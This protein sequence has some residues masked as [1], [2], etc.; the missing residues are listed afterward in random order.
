MA[1]MATD[2]TASALTSATIG[3]GRTIYV[4]STAGTSLSIQGTTGVTTFDGII[5]DKTS[6]GILVKQ[7]TGTLILGGASTYTGSTSINNGT[8]KLQTGNDRLPIGTTLNIGQATSTNLGTFD[9]NGFNQQIAGLV[10]TSGTNT[11]TSKNTVTS[12]T[13]AT[14]TIGGSGDYSY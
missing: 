1:S 7:V 4:G 6:N 14:L 11:T 10:S 13:A 12:A 8:I 5:A 3:S 9:L 2:G